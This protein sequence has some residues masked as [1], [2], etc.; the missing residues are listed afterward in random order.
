VIFSFREGAHLRDLVAPDV[1]VPFDLDGFGPAQW[2]WLK[3]ST[4]ILVWDPRHS[5]SI[6]SGLQL[7]GS[8]TWWMFWRDGYQALA[9]LDDNRDG[10]L[11]GAELDGIAVWIDRNQN[12]HSDPGEV[13]SLAAAGIARIGVSAV[14]DAT[15]VLAN[16][17][18]IEFADGRRTASFDWIAVARTSPPKHVSD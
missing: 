9:A 14:P 7:F 3:P 2:S 8:V 13:I 6:D 1:H 17:Q 10:W 18:G 5:E 12:G 15:G 16:S 11:S 4:G